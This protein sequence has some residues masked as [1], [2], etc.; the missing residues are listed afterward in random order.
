MLTL[1]WLYLA[2]NQIIDM[3]GGTAFYPMFT[4]ATFVADALLI[5]ALCARIRGK[6]K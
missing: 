2:T 4:F 3:T 6:H 5:G 1:V